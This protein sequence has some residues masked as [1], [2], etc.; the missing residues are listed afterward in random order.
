MKILI[1]VFIFI[2]LFFNSAFSINENVE[3][4]RIWLIPVLVEGYDDMV[5]TEHDKKKWKKEFG[6][7][8]NSLVI[9]ENLIDNF[10]KQQLINDKLELGYPD[11]KRLVSQKPIL[12]RLKNFVETYNNTLPEQ[13]PKIQIVIRFLNWNSIFQEIESVLSDNT[14]LK[15]DIIELGSTWVS[16]F[17]ERGYLNSFSGYRALY[18]EI[19]KTG[20][21]L[22]YTT[23]IRILL[24]WKRIPGIEDEMPERTLEGSWSNIFKELL[25]KDQLDAPKICIPLESTYN[26]LHNFVPLVWASGHNFLDKKFLS[27]QVKLSKPQIIETLYSFSEMSRQGLL[28]FPLK[29]TQEEAFNYFKNGDKYLGMILPSKYIKNLYSHFI[30]T[31]PQLS[32]K[33]LH[34][35]GIAIPPETFKGGSHLVIHNDANNKLL[36]NNLIKFLITDK[37]IYS[38]YTK[39][40]MLMTQKKF[41]I[42]NEYGLTDILKTNNHF[43]SN[44]EIVRIKRK[45]ILAINKGHEYVPFAGWVDIESDIVLKSLLK[46]W[47]TIATGNKSDIQHI[48]NNVESIINSKIYWLNQ[49]IRIRLI[50]VPL[51]I[52]FLIII[53]FVSYYLH[54]KTKNE[55]DILEK[56]RNNESKMI[57][58]LLLVR[59]KYHS[60]LGTQGTVIYDFAYLDSCDELRAKIKKYGITISKDYNKYWVRIIR[61]V[62]NELA[63]VFNQQ[64]IKKIIENAFFAAKTE[65]YINWAKKSADIEIQYNNIDTYKLLKYC[66][67]LTFV[68]HEWLYNAIK[69]IPSN[70]SENIK[71]S[72]NQNELYIETP[73][74]I[75]AED[76]TRLINDEVS[77]QS[78]F[79]KGGQGLNIIRDLLWF[80]FQTKVR[81]ASTF[82]Q[83]NPSRRL[84]L[85]I[86]LPL[87]NN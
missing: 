82:E 9:C 73:S 60:I 43:L 80:C 16:Y 3:Q 38:F 5:I 42:N 66:N 10:L 34:Y 6:D 11:W 51:I 52:F 37:E 83:V 33:F 77:I 57:I 26:I 67:I 85:I 71:V 86:Q 62:L 76:I 35:A 46:L 20:Y 36:C 69:E 65:F 56:L 63:D 68:L 8:N 48:L 32:N 23:D 53:L 81:L 59:G 24:Y 14:Q 64:S 27:Y 4:I 74:Q 75:S 19:G 39:C 70:T 54:K 17:Q 15:P 55:K 58:A 87:L 49:Y 40:G 50:I 28:V 45:V 84:L 13:Q 79:K 22:P 31:N 29:V 12:D 1:M 2:T 25:T 30:K 47:S 21:S 18:N 44:E 41:D 7:I 78:I 72:I 61:G